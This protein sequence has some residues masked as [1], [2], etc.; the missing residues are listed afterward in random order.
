MTDNKTASDMATFLIVVREVVVGQDLAETIAEDRP[1]ARVIIVATLEDALVSLADV[2][3]LE[4][5]FIAADPAVLES[6]R[7]TPALAARGGQVVL[8]GV[9]ADHPPATSS[10]KLLPFP[11]TTE[12]VLRLMAAGHRLTLPK[13]P[14]ARLLSSR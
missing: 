3:T 9:W 4:I 11:F 1:N 10:W 2:A 6:S 8:M 12:D 7:L 5:A 14:P 13:S